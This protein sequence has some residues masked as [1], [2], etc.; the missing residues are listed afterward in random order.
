MKTDVKE[1]AAKSNYEMLNQ[2]KR[3]NR[4]AASEQKK[5]TKK[6]VNFSKKMKIICEKFGK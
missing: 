6:S 3:P 2:I 4:G 5:K 1:T